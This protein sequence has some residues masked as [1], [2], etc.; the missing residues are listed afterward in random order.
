MLSPSSGLQMV[1]KIIMSIIF[2]SLFLFLTLQSFYFLGKFLLLLAAMDTDP[3]GKSYYGE[4]KLYLSQLEQGV[5]KKVALGTYE[6][7]FQ[8][9]L[10]KFL[11]WD[12]FRICSFT[13][14]KMYLVLFIV[15]NGTRKRMISLLY[16]EMYLHMS[17]YMIVEGSSFIV[18]VEISTTM[19]HLTHKALDFYSE[20]LATF[21][22]KWYVYTLYFR[23]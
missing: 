1:Y 18:L 8:S 5:S 22:E 2:L 15:Q 14:F 3:T 11:I 4:T 19:L 16:M 13:F 10:I 21:W 9:I 20:G 17:P 7:L 12:S 6:M 23:F